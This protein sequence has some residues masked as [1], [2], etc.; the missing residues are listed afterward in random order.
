M[1]KVNVM[2]V[3]FSAKPAVLEK[4]VS[5]RSAPANR[6]LGSSHSA[7]NTLAQF[8]ALTSLKIVIRAVDINFY[9]MLAKQFKLSGPCHRHQFQL[10]FTEVVT[11][12]RE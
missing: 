9:S 7:Y 11:G 10:T 1:G 3:V 8:H 5:H 6:V 2:L 12:G 4:R